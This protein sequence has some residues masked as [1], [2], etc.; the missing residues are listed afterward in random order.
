[1]QIDDNEPDQIT[2][3]MNSFVAVNYKD[4]REVAP[5]PAPAKEAAKAT[6]DD[7]LAGDDDEDDDDFTVDPTVD[8]ETD[9]EDD[10][11]DEPRGTEEN[12]DDDDEVVV[13]EKP[14]K[15]AQKRFDEITRARRL[16]ERERDAER[17]ANIRLK[18][19]LA[20][21]KSGKKT[22]EQPAK[23][24]AKSALKEATDLGVDLSDLDKPDPADYE[25]AELSPEYTD[26]LSTYMFEVNQRVAAK[27]NEAKT[28]EKAVSEANQ[29]AFDKNIAPALKDP[30]M[31]DFA[32]VVLKG[33]AEKKWPLSDQLGQLLVE[34]EH[35]ARISYHL[36]K[37]LEKA[38]QVYDMTPAAQAKWLGKMEAKLDAV[39]PKTGEK[40][41]EKSE[42]TKTESKVIK[43]P[44]PVEKP[45]GRA[46]ADPDASTADFA[47]FE[48][49]V[50]KSLGIGQP[51]VRR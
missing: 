31:P 46:K 14:K 6:S 28:A 20:A 9:D 23:K 10:G 34:S 24:T 8:P 38:K 32:E 44:E 51:R 33:A 29:A 37:N 13:E 41:S 11:D 1:M 22:E 45:R 12:P 39:K 35:G 19:E 2:A 50:N 30:T 16:A 21:L 49:M 15:S 40:K 48:A 25:F 7:P 4:G 42:K 47:T 17:E 26:A 5:T 18:E 36:A 27:K 43:L 3:E